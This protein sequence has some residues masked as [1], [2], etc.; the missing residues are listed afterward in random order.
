MPEILKYWRRSSYA[1]SYFIA[2]RISSRL[3]LGSSRI[4][5]ASSLMVGSA[6]GITKAD[7]S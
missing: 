2:S 5:T 7:S 1:G 4:S 3:L 6:E